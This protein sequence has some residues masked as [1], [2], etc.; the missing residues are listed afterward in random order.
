MEEYSM[1]KNLREDLLVLSKENKDILD[2]ASLTVKIVSDNGFS[3]TDYEFCV[4]TEKNH[5]SKYYV[6]AFYNYEELPIGMERAR[7]WQQFFSS[8]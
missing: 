2:K 1:L 8:N 3:G 5:P 7:N 4:T 6:G